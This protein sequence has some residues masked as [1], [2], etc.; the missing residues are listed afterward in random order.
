MIFEGCIHGRFQPFHN[1]HLAYA[2]AAAQRCEFLWVGLSRPFPAAQAIEVPA[3]RRDTESNP[4]T[5][6]ER[7]C[8][9]AAALDEAGLARDRFAVVP[10]PIDNPALLPDYVPPTITVFTTINDDWNRKKAHLLLEAGY[11]VEIL[12]EREKGIDSTR[13]RALAAKRDPAWRDLVPPA[14][15]RYLNSIDFEERLTAG[16]KSQTRIRTRDVP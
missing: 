7:H 3:H 2:L 8:M 11:R 16:H 10:F 5:Y 15:V 14:V 1:E 6:H 4:L 13:V 9:V 12:W